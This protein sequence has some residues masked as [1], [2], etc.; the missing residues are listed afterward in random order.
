MSKGHDKPLMRSLGEFFGEVW[1]GVKADPAASKRTV[2]R[3][4]TQERAVEGPNGQVILRRT[5]VEEI[6]VPPKAPEA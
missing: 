1:R 3:T 2:T 5:T 4:T 6:I